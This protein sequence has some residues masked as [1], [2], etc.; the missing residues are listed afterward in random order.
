MNLKA[1]VVSAVLAVSTI[2]IPLANAAEKPVVE[3]FLFTPNE[4]DLSTTNTVVNIE[5]VVS[6]P[7]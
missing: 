6:H 1:I 5:L 7:S 2:W 3:S 4:I